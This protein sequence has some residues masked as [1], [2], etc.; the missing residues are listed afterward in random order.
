LLIIALVPLLS[1]GSERECDT[2]C[3]YKSAL[4]AAAATADRI[5]V[6]EHASGMEHM[7]PGDKS[8]WVHGP[9]TVYREKELTAAARAEFLQRLRAMPSKEPEFYV[10]CVPEYH[11][12]V[13][14]HS[15]QKQSS[16]LLI[17][18]QCGQTQ[19]DGS[20]EA[21]PDALITVLAATVKVAGFELE[22]DW[23]ALA[24]AAAL[25]RSR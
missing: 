7:V 16:R 3:R 12:S 20:P 1:S 25:S 21:E 18:F 11:H 4:V 17:C 24:K 9:M 23:K 14:F 2:Y 13:T 5:V 15:A 6:S 19:W 22:R 10:A 8:T